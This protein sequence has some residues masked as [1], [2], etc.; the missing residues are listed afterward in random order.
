MKQILVIPTWI[1]ARIAILFLPKNHAWKNRRF[2]LID[3]AEHSTEVN[4][5]FSL[6]FWIS[7]MCLLFIGFFYCCA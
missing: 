4:N 1:L 7:G 2:T 6:F 5:S 3:W